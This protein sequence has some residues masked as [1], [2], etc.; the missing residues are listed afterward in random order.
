MEKYLEPALTG[1]LARSDSPPSTGRYP[2]YFM[3]C[4]IMRPMFCRAT[5]FLF[6][7]MTHTGT[8]DVSSK[9]FSVFHR[10]FQLCV[11]KRPPEGRKCSLPEIF[12]SSFFSSQ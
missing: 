12:L 8:L 10:N 9:R 1:I 11:I 3:I 6:L 7:P 5:A 2:K 4:L